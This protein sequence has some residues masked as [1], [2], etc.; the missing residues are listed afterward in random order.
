MNLRSTL[1]VWLLAFVLAPTVVRA[2]QPPSNE[3]APAQVRR[4]FRGIFG[5]PAD[6]SS[7]Q[8]LDLSASVFGAYDD[9]VFADQV[10]TLA[11]SDPGVRQSGVYGGLT[12]GLAYMRRG[13]RASLGL[14]GDF[15]LNKYEDRDPLS[16]YR[17]GADV[18]VQ[19]ARRTSLSVSSAVVYSPEFR[20]GVFA[21][22][23]SLTGSLDPFTTVLPDFNL[24]SL[25]AY[26]T[27][28]AASLKQSI[29][30]GSSLDFFYS[31]SHVDYVSDPFDYRSQTAGFRYLHRLSRNVSARLGYAY[32]GADYRQLL[33]LRP[34]RIH[35]ID[36]GIDYGRALS[37]SRR[38]H[39]SFSTGS[40]VVAADTEPIGNGGT[41]LF[42]RVIGS[43]DL[44][45][46]T[47]RTWTTRLSYRRGI[48]FHEGFRDPFLSDAVSAGLNGFIARR[49]KFSSG[50]DYAFG[51]VGVTG[52]SGYSSASANAGLEFALS[53]VVA[54]F[55]RY[56]YYR[57]EF[58]R[59]VALDPRLARSFDRQGCGSG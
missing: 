57:Y 30:A 3:P 56:V 40:A 13:D 38:T 21:D 16:T 2:G 29:G 26:R 19:V 25:A 54:L 11:T 37:F 10:G 36:A 53:R 39:F 32:S 45:H 28:A 34:Y 8:S 20:L 58:D 6:P 23:A 18:G 47:G 51:K 59:Q 52:D 41:D 43:A 14:T 46:E 5:A 22:P 4:P 42:Y 15:G 12:A 24:Y 33:G 27:S 48:D 49:L 50:A 9:D 35:N 31:V 1:A 7:K 44:T 17:A 55:G